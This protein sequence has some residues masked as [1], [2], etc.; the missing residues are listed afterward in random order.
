MKAQNSKRGRSMMESFLTTGDAAKEMRMT[1]QGVISAA[2][3]GRLPVACHTAGGVRLFRREDVER[4]AA[5]RARKH[6]QEDQ[7]KK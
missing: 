4:F 7:G 3:A 2:K 1:T 5:E 6:I